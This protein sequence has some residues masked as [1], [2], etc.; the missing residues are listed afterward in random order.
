VPSPVRRR[1]RGITL[2]ETV[3]A[4]AII[5]MMSIGTLG[6]VSA[7]LRAAARAR[8]GLEASVLAT[9]RVRQLDLLTELELEA[10]PDSVA[11]G[12]FP[13]P[14]DEYAWT[15]A[16]SNRSTEQG[17][18]D[19]VVTVTWPDGSYALKTAIFR[20]PMILTQ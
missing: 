5:G 10:L 3:V 2:M 20:R 16:V 1:R 11:K 7:D 18:H 6:A 15:T 4:L 17:V 12:T 13:A 8:R 9:E 14:L 19:V